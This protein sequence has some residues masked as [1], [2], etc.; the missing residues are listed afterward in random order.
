MK[1]LSILALTLACIGAAPAAHAATQ[2]AVSIGINAPG[3]YG[4]IDFNNYPQAVLITQQPVIYLRETVVVQQ[5]P[6]YLYAPTGHQA[7]WGRY[8]R[9]YQA[10][11][12]PVYFVRE[13][14]VRAQYGREREERKR[15]KGPKPKDRDH[16]DNGRHGGK[17]H[18]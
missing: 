15:G 6:I 4:R 2:I 5:A 13:D 3:Q 17:D 10:C 11:G 16:R 18:D 8:C 1:K 12:R 9:R 14:W 7:N